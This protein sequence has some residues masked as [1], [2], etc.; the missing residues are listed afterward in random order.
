MIKN[1]KKRNLPCA[2]IIKSVKGVKNGL[3]RAGNYLAENI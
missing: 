3:S 1:I 2:K